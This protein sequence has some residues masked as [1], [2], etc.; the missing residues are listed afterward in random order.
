M[1]DQSSP[2]PA[3]DGAPQIE[4]I[5]SLVNRA[6]EVVSSLDPIVADIESRRATANGIV[7]QLQAAATDF[8]EHQAALKQS[9]TEG[10]ANAQ[11]K[12]TELESAITSARSKLDEAA[13]DLSTR[14]QAGLASIEAALQQSNARRDEA[15]NSANATNEELGRAR[16]LLNEI[17]VARGEADANQQVTAQAAAAKQT[18]DQEAAA[19][20][21]RYQAS[22]DDADKRKAEFQ[23]SY[24]ASKEDVQNLTAQAETML[25]GA[26]NAGIA[27]T[28]KEEVAA[29]DK[30]IREAERMFLLGIAAIGVSLI[31]LIMYMLNVSAGHDLTIQSV[32]ARTALL[33]P[34]VWLTRHFARRIHANFE[35][36]QQYVH[37][38]SMGAIVEPFRRQAGEHAPNVVAGVAGELMKNPAEV[39][40][41]HQ[42][43]GDGPAEDMSDALGPVTRLLPNPDR[44]N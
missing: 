33:I 35:L 9:G 43:M 19:L 40:K 20:L 36:R 17:Q 34:S 25:F 41:R 15:A 39:L 18:F 14:G 3:N 30:R 12:L 27:S 7:D 10:T 4:E 29:L 6:R 31:P 22:L 42:K 23:S 1:E 8:A 38:Y 26:T 44:P 24:A 16:Q 13:A 37:K 11:S 21:A 5:V 28:F 2:L 32:L